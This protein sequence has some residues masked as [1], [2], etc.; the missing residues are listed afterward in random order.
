[1]AYWGCQTPKTQSRPD[2]HQ[3]KKHT[4]NHRAKV[5]EKRE[6]EAMELTAVRH[7][8]TTV[9]RLASSSVSSPEQTNKASCD[10]TKSNPLEINSENFEAKVPLYSLVLRMKAVTL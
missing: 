10:A 4:P 1:M 3:N 2:F 8:I 9:S 7:I 5:K 6:H